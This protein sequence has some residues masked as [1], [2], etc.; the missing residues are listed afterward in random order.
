MK[1]LIILISIVISNFVFGQKHRVVSGESPDSLFIKYSEK[2]F[3]MERTRMREKIYP[4]DIDTIMVEDKKYKLKFVEMI[5]D[6]PPTFE[7]FYGLSY[8]CYK[9]GTDYI[10]ILLSRNTG[11]QRD[12]RYFYEIIK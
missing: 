9:Y 12:T 6:N 10:V 5:G 11:M 1:N 7:D 4:A 8:S 3:S 2:V